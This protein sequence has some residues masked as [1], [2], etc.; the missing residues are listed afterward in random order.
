MLI[1]PATWLIGLV[2]DSSDPA[3]DQLAGLLGVGGEV[4]ISVEDL[5]F[6][7][8]RALDRLRLLDLD[9]HFGAVE[10]RLRV[11]LDDRAGRLVVAVAGAD[12][13]ARAALDPDLVAVRGELARALGRQPD[14]VL[15]VLDLAD[16][17]DAHGRSPG[18]G[19]G[20]YD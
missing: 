11:G 1:R 4:E 16:G 19:P 15:V 3:F 7:E 13:Q 20:R 10:H 5:P 6:A 8:H 12:A 17:T 14:A 2:G 9:D 18:F